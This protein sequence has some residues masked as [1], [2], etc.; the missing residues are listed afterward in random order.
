MA[1]RSLWSVLMVAWLSAGNASIAPYDA[2]VSDI[3]VSE[4]EHESDPVAVLEGADPANPGAG[5]ADAAEARG[6]S[7]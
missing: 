4:Q 1:G 2:A 6:G 7:R 5:T 3:A